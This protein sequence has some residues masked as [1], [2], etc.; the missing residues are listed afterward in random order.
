MS[1]QNII[2]KKTR[3]LQLLLDSG[4]F[5]AWTKKVDID[6]DDYIAFYFR[7]QN[8][9]NYLV[10]LDVIPGGFGRSPSV[11]EV[12]KSA[13]KGFDNYLYMLSKG[14]PKERLIHVFHQGER[15]EWVQKMLKF[16]IPYIGLSPANDRVTSSKI[17]WLDECMRYVTDKRG[18]PLVKFHGF[19]VTSVPIM[20]RYPWYS[21]D[22]V[23]WIKAAAYGTVL[24][25][26]KKNGRYEYTESNVITISSISPKNKVQ[27]QSFYSF[28]KMEQ[29]EIVSFIESKGF[30]I[31]ESTFDDDGNEIIVEEGLCNNL[32]QRVYFNA[33]F[34]IEVQKRQPEWPWPFRQHIFG[35]GL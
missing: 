32:S 22:S 2:K 10:N 4:A 5:S 35:L 7:Y 29:K 6:I 11:Q 9:I 28:T 33:L 13:Q 26:I 24:L 27:G 21:V 20:V 14:V 34:L 19:A 1:P 17:K 23:R 18:Y 25:P 15:F 8:E 31:G 30:I 16:G 3:K 12:E